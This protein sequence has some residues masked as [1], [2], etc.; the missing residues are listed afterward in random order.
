MAHTSG[1]VFNWD[2]WNAEAYERIDHYLNKYDRGECTTPYITGGETPEPT[3]SPD[4]TGY[5][6]K[7]DSIQI[8]PCSRIDIYF[9]GGTSV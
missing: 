2:E 8:L 5:C 1:R 4:L 7:I 9:S 6:P 3:A